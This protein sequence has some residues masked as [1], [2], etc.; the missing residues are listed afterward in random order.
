LGS[1][2]AESVVRGR[3]WVRRP[4]LRLGPSSGVEAESEPWGRVRWSPSSGVEV[5]PEH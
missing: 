3:G 1:G 2:E 4:R 5:E